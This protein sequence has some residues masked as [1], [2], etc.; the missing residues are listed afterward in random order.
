MT[1][2]TVN[3]LQLKPNTLVIKGNK[4]PDLTEVNHLRILM[5][6]NIFTKRVV[7]NYIES[8]SSIIGRLL[9]YVPSLSQL[10]MLCIK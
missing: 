4:L 10:T 1:T 9:E 6:K 3:T 8:P 2:A 5:E 7:L